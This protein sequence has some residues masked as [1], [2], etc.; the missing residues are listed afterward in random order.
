ASFMAELNRSA[1]QLQ[2]DLTTTAQQLNQQLAQLGSE[3]TLAEKGRY[4]AMLEQIRKQTEA[5]LANAQA[6]IQAHQADLATK[7]EAEH[8]ALTAKMGEQVAAEQA[9]LLKQIDTKLADAVASFLTDTLQ[10]NVDLG[11]QSNYLIAQLE[12]HKQEF[13]QEVSGEAPTAK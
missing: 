2:A 3:V 1:T 7:L 9:R 12:E 5:S 11:A 10:H 4:D 6:E 8:A 13:K